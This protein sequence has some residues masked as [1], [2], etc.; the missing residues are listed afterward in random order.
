MFGGS[1]N[2]FLAYNYFV[3]LRDNYRQFRPFTDAEAWLLF[4]VAAIAE[5]CGWTLLISG[6]LIQKY[7]TPHS[8]LP[9][10]IAG[11]VHGTI[12]LIYFVAAVILAPSLSWPTRR[13]AA[14]LLCGVPPYGSLFF[15]M[16]AAHH[17]RKSQL[18]RLNLLV[19]YRLLVAAQQKAA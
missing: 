15:E 9:V 12:Y 17:R 8:K 6:I 4:R 13:A 18:Q 5:A 16:W 11:Q 1:Q 2:Y 3:S 14:A 10:L 7:V 19:H